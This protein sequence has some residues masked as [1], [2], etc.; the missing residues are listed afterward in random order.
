MHWRSRQADE[1]QH[2][3]RRSQHAQKMQYPLFPKAP[4]SG[5]MGLT[6]VVRLLQRIDKEEHMHCDEFGEM[7][8][9]K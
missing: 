5:R 9:R 6:E 2:A 7:L 8:M 4:S 3:G 1:R